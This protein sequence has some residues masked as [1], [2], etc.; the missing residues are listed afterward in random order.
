[1]ETCLQSLFLISGKG[2]WSFERWRNRGASWPLFALNPNVFSTELQGKTALQILDEHRR[3]QIAMLQG[4]VVEIL[5]D[6]P[7]SAGGSSITCV[8]IWSYYRSWCGLQAQQVP[9]KFSVQ[10]HCQCWTYHGHTWFQHTISNHCDVHVTCL[11]YPKVGP[12]PSHSMDITEAALTAEPKEIVEEPP[13]F[14]LKSKHVHVNDSCTH[15]YVH[16]MILRFAW[17]EVHDMLE[18]AEIPTADP[19]R[20]GLRVWNVS[21]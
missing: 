18:Q 15:K 11:I 12:R 19:A 6:G 1:M 10:I 3:Q 5:D 8:V 21:G 2:R 14:V 16:E 17:Q 7:S 13:S 4:K 20:F 9:K